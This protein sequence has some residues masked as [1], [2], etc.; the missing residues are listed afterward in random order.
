MHGQ[1]RRTPLLVEEG[2][3]TALISPRC[4]CG[5]LR[6]W[7]GMCG[8]VSRDLLVRLRENFRPLS[9]PEGGDFG[10]IRSAKL[11]KNIT[12]SNFLIVGVLEKY[13]LSEDS[14]FI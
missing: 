1:R 3:I 10:Q 6:R 7:D 2:G 4:W 8:R 14:G 13:R 5:L 11:P 9:Q 12:N